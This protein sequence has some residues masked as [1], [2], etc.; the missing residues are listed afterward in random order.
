[1][2]EFARSPHR[3]HQEL[4]LSYPSL[5]ASSSAIV[6]WDPKWTPAA[7]RA[8]LQN[9]YQPTP[10]CGKIPVLEGWQKVNATTEDI[11]AWEKS[12]PDAINTGILTRQTPAIDI[13]VLNQEVAEIIHRWVK[14]L[15]PA[16]CPELVRIGLPPK[17][18]IL[19]RCDTP[20]AKISTGK[21]ID[22]E[23]SKIEHELEIL[24]LGQKITVYGNHPD[25]GKAYIWTGARPGQTPWSTLP[26]LTEEMARSLVDRT[27]VLFKERGWRPKVDERP[28]E[29]PRPRATGSA[30]GDARKISA[31]LAERIEELPAPIRNNPTSAC[32]SHQSASTLF[33]IIGKVLVDALG[34]ENWGFPGT[35]VLL[36][37]YI[38]SRLWS[39][40][41]QPSSPQAVAL[42][43]ALSQWNDIDLRT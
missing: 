5:T 16:G 31:A 4:N 42:P 29:P 30:D 7:R 41:A 18:A 20:F 12:H 28:K 21:W 19:F 11:A 17:R 40:A 22:D 36:W 43:L 9:G 33:E 37:K 25:T 39:S 10:E 35:P 38:D 1:L 15:I 6:L 3:E 32:M 2:P 26:L 14:E 13:D 27:K 8:L 23:D 24:C 34:G